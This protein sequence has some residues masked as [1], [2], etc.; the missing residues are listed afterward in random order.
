MSLDNGTAS[1]PNGEMKKMR[2]LYGLLAGV[3]LL[4]FI[5]AP[6]TS[7]VLPV[8]GTAS[9]AIA[10][11]PSPQLTG[12]GVGSS[13]GGGIASHPALVLGTAALVTISPTFVGLAFIT[14]PTGNSLPAGVG[15]GANGIVGA[16][17]FFA[18]GMT[19]AG[20]VPLGPIGGG[21]TTMFLVGPLGGTLLGATWQGAGGTATPVVF[22]TM[23]AALAI[24]ITVTA[25]AYDNRTLSGL[26][27][28]QFVAPATGSIGIFGSLPVFG[29]LTLSYTPEPGT[30]LLLGSGIA[31][32][33]VLGRK[34]LRG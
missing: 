11:L 12:T 34:K 13:L 6:A 17:N 15:A 31:G 26:G 3:A 18:A 21:G 7:A 1:E 29:T 28:V 27:T 32:L 33:A 8:S 14:V 2:K 19:P 9:I 30:L 24:P 25:T 4:G 5:A 22:S 16:A 10:T 23:A 20:A